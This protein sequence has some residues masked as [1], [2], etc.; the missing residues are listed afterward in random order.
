MKFMDLSDTGVHR[1]PALVEAAVLEPP[2][3]AIGRQFVWSGAPDTEVLYLGH[4]KCANV[5]IDLFQALYALDGAGAVTSGAPFLPGGKIEEILLL[6]EGSMRKRSLS[7]L[8]QTAGNVGYTEPD[9]PCEEHVVEILM[10]DRVTLPTAQPKWLSRDCAM[11]PARGGALLHWWDSVDLSKSRPS[12]SFH[13]MKMR[14]HL[15]AD[16]VGEPASYWLLNEML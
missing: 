15:F 11:W 13:G 7:R 12:L 6:R 9:A 2:A 16:Q 4:M 10:R 3:V 8:V 14:L 5:G 1:A